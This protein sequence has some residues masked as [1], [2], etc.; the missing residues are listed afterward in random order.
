MQE[1]EKRMTRF[2]DVSTELVRLEI[3]L[4]NGLDANLISAASITLPQFQALETVRSYAGEARVQDISQ[5]M[6]ITVGA[7]SKVVDRLERDGLARRTAHP[8]D[9]R[10]SIVSLTEQG[11]SAI[12]AYSGEASDLTQTELHGFLDSVAAGHARVPIGRTFTLEDIMQAHTLMESGTAG[13][14]I[15]VLPR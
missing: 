6:T 2:T 1:V 13:G 4:W 14:K 10:S 15:V 11:A 12:T 5:R 9:R 8:T 7:T 3:E